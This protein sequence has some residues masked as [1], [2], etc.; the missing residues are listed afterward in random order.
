MVGTYRRCG[1]SRTSSPRIGVLVSFKGGTF[2]AGPMM[3]R[4]PRK[5]GSVAPAIFHGGERRMVEE[6]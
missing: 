1:A 6:P 4:R 2:S 5:I 3:V